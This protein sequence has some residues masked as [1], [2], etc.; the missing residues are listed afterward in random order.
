MKLF[1]SSILSLVI[2]GLAQ[3]QNV[4]I[5]NDAPLMKLHVS[6]EGSNVLLLENSESLNSNISNGLYFKTGEGGFPY[7]GAIKSIGQS[8]N[9]AR[10]GFF[11][12]ASPNA[13][14]LLERLSIT[15]AGN[16]G[17]GTSSPVTSAALDVTSIEKGFLPP[18]MTTTQRDN[19]VSPVAGLTIYNSSVNA[20]QCYNGTNWYSTVHYV[21]ENYGG[22]I[23]FYV[24]D[25]GQHGLIASTED[26]SADVR[27]HGGSVVITR[28]QANGI[29]AGLKNT[30]I[31]IANQG[32]VDGEPFAATL[33]NEYSVVQSGVTYGDWYLP[34]RHELEL[35]FAQKAIVGGFFTEN[36]WCSTETNQFFAY[37]LHFN[38]GAVTPN[39]K[40]LL[41]RVRAIRSF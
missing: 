18:R 12:Y 40:S 41:N 34:S 3:A 26:Q 2:I 7:T 10:L 36:Y 29:N 17:V 22:G 25:N 16:V 20:F 27:W 9:E 38:T 37:Q 31:I 5:D 19:I 15:D 1:W 32:S 24:Y 30:A 13:T 35:L 33:C 28:A 39:Q 23:V 21:G 11:T 8:A 4:G 6:Q 14:E